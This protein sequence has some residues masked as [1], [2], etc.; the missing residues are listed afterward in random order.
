[1]TQFFQRPNFKPSFFLH[2]WLCILTIIGTC[3]APSPSAHAQNGVN[4]S[5]TFDSLPI[6]NATSPELRSIQDLFT[7]LEAA[8]TARD[9]ATLRFFG[10]ERVPS[11]YSSLVLQSRLTHIA[12][13]PAN[14]AT[15]RPVGHGALVRQMYRISGISGDRTRTAALTGGIQELWLDRAPD[16]NF[17]FTAQ[18]WA[19]PAEAVTALTDAAREE[20]TEVVQASLASA[21]SNAASEANDGNLLH[22]VAEQRGGRWIA[23]RRSRW[24][25]NVID[26]VTL[27]RQEA[28][29][30]PG[31]GEWLQ[32]Q[33]NE[34]PRG[35]AGVAHFIMQRGKKGWVGLGTA[36]EPN[37]RLDPGMENAA[38]LSR[39]QILSTTIYL[40][41]AAHR[42]FG[43][44][45]V[46]AGLFVEAHEELE[47]AEALQPGLVG[48]AKLREVSA[49]R[50]KDP[51]SVVARQL[52]NERKVG[53]GED[54][55]A[56][57][58]Q[59]LAKVWNTQPTPLF[60]LR[61]G[62]EYSK[63]AEDERAGR[64]LRVAEDMIKN[65]GSRNVSD[66]DAAWI[67]IL[68]DHL[69]DRKRLYA[70]KPPNLIRSALFTVRC[71]PN[72]LSTIQ[73]LGALES[74]QHTI[75]DE[76][77]LPMSNTE[78][79]LWRT[80]SDFQKYTTLFS[81]QAH[82]EFVAALTLTKLIPTRD[83]PMVLG[84]EVNVFIDPRANLFSTVA[85]EY[86]H[87]AVRQLSRGRLVPV[88]FNEGIAALVEGGYD[89]YL[90]R[91]NSAARADS[92]LSMQE[93]QQWDV[94]GERAFLAYSQANSMVDFI[95][96][97][98]G[99]PALLEILRQIGRDVDPD[100]AF[101]T[102]LKHS[103]QDLWLRWAREGIR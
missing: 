55:P 82:S 92:L 102:V 21:N 58:I 30:N 46:N 8:V 69:R 67:D 72:D 90:P 48:V 49:A 52:S 35:R 78:V 27:A 94:D 43:L 2:T 74:A 98:W 37:N 11:E 39:R 31:V 103:Q 86:G 29:A 60:A 96:A 63:L 19:Q 97:K 33:I 14:P 50:D 99:R 22:L 42:D 57:V 95:I 73:L 6:S 10:I 68:L 84:E 87:V 79:V 51:Q 9:P 38:A 28:T 70:Y 100:V 41:A 101:R 13:A 56:T 71:W 12:V 7:R 81:K 62:L 85:H 54:H 93:L 24:E 65:G 91:V 5:T 3:S 36:W 4:A 53:L 15:G 17:T 89:G 40:D 25:G 23:L 83:G 66:A 44:A 45:L 32:R 26:P 47:K 16:G 18:R 88:W 59:G 64:W 1:M 20:W 76:F 75:Y 77:G 34:A 80:Q 61:I